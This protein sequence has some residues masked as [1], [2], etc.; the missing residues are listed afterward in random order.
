MS[1]TT[2][3]LVSALVDRRKELGLS[4]RQ[5]D[6]MIG[7]SES[8]VAKWESGM[9]FPTTKSLERWASALGFQVQLR[10]RPVKQ[11]RKH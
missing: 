2:T 11:K 5:L 8:M 1:I 9:R 4:Q 7:V 10:P 6:Q 3:S